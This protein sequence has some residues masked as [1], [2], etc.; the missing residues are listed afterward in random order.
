MEIDD[1][2]KEAFAKQLENN[3]KVAEGGYLYIYRNNWSNEILPVYESLE[4]FK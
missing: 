1:A 2:F 4:I 3:H